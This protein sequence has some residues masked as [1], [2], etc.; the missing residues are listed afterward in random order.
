M[1]DLQFR[2]TGAVYSSLG[3]FALRAAPTLAVLVCTSAFVCAGC[4]LR[5]TDLSQAKLDY[6]SARDSPADSARDDSVLE[7]LRS[8]DQAIRID[9]LR[10][11]SQHSRE[12]FPGKAIELIDDPEPSVRRAA[13]LAVG[14]AGVKAALPRARKA[15]RDGEPSVRL[16]GIAALGGIGGNEA[17]DELRDAAKREGEVYQVAAVAELG[18]LS[19]WP[20]VHDAADDKSWRVRR[21]AAAALTLDPSPAAVTTASALLVDSASQVQQAA[22]E[23]VSQWPLYRAGP[24]LL[25]GLESPHFA[26]RQAALS[27]LASRWP[28]AQSIN[29][30]DLQPLNPPRDKIENLRRAW[31]EQFGGAP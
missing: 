28:A 10:Q 2:I 26:T 9:A 29:L 19:D 31:V 7:L 4:H 12:D 23:S 20:A 11:L 27:A 18:K 22:V 6:L 3:V 14:T 25:S 13:L 30:A 1:N 16:A 24:L 15:A 5:R 21:A 17:L 8:S